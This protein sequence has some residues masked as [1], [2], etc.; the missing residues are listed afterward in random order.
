[1][2]EDTFHPIWTQEPRPPHFPDAPEIDWLLDS[3]FDPR[4]GYF[5]QRMKRRNARA[6]RRAIFGPKGIRRVP[7]RP[8]GVVEL[9]CPRVGPS[10]SRTTPREP[11]TLTSTG[12]RP[13]MLTRSSSRREP[14]AL[15]PPGTEPRW[16]LSPAT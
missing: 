4:L 10:A 12:H 2:L 13:A 7:G 6:L 16:R 11:M 3:H 9:D 15:A 8:G 1:M 5:K 14:A